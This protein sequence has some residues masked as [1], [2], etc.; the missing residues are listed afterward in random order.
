MR[1]AEYVWL[2]GAEDRPRLR[3]KT[4]MIGWDEIPEWS[5]DGG[6]TYQ[7]DVHNSDLIL[8]PVRTYNDPFRERGIIVLC[9]VLNQD[10]TPHSTNHR[11]ELRQVCDLDVWFGFEQEYTLLGLSRKPAAF[12]VGANFREQ[13]PFYCGVGAYNVFHRDLVEKHFQA[14]ITAGISMHGYNAEVMPGQWEFQTAPKDAVVASDDL[15]VARYLLDRVF[16][17]A[18]LRAS[19]H[20]KPADGWNGAGCHTNFSTK[21]MRQ[22]WEGIEEAIQRLSSRHE[23]HMKVYG[24]DNHLRMTGD[25]ETSDPSEFS[26]GSTDR[27]CSIRIPVTV[28]NKKC[29]YLEDRR[30]AANIDPY[31]VCTRITKSIVLDED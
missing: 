12:E 29:G 8:L 9:E 4:R 31:Q 6:S 11:H 25:C 10:R 14:C 16:E 2:D 30:P 1:V 20:P 28:A 18:N 24:T 5:Y 3:S 15:W 27:A 13:G 26:V 21:K 23:A 22:S 7:A 17:S 19:L